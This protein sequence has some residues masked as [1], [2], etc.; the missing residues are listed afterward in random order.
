MPELH[1][2]GLH[3][4]EMTYDLIRLWAD[5]QRAAPDG[6]RQTWDD[7]S[8]CTQE[9]LAHRMAESSLWLFESMRD[10]YLIEVMVN[11]PAGSFDF[12]D[13]GQV[14]SGPADL[15]QAVYDEQYLTP[16]GQ[17]LYGD[18]SEA[19]PEASFR[20]AFFLHFLDP[21]LPLKTPLGSVDLPKPTPMPERLAKLV[22]YDPPT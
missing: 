13:V 6:K 15:R 18:G 20:A 19:P 4:V 2:I 1:V 10:L 7:F 9:E 12:S 11:C 22:P 5:Y 8:P 3:R 14:E 21:T 17:A 16:N